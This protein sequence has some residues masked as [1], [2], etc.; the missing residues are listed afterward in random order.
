MVVEQR[1]GRIDRFGQ[2][3]DKVFIHNLVIE[4]TVEETILERLYKRIGIFERSV[5]AIEA[6]LGDTMQKLQR[7]YLNAKMTPDEAAKR[8]EQEA[9]AIAQREQLNEELEQKASQLFG[10]EEYVRSELARVR[11]LG[12]FVGDSA[13]LSILRTFFQVR[14][15]DIKIK[16]EGQDLYAIKMTDQLRMDIHKAAKAAT[17]SWRDRSKNGV[18]RFTTSGEL[19]FEDSG[20]ELI[21]STHP[22]IRAAI[23]DLRKQMEEPKARL[24]AA[25]LEVKAEDAKV[26]PEGNYLVFMAPQIVQGVRN[27][28]LIETI[29]IRS[30]DEQLLSSDDGQRLLYLALETGRPWDAREDN[31]ASAE[32]L[33]KMK[34][35]LTRRTSALR[36]RE[37][38]ENE[39]LYLRRRRAL[40]AEHE[41]DLALK[42]RRLETARSKENT[43]ILPAFEGQ[44]AKAQAEFQQELQNLEGRQHA[45]VSSGE[46][47]SICLVHVSHCIRKGI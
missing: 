16:E 21:G 29:A 11:K 5:G 30:E 9:N 15:L 23:E 39:A 43:K 18:L 35:E 37:Q 6:I 25:W 31:T 20:L 3:S 7:D 10:N 34:S 44:I 46:P 19:A 1:I 33:T 36:N 4:G 12:Q 22:L 28:R 45:S 24:G 38:G 26:F 2:K 8:V 32:T 40:E 13:L 14:H 47:I 27:R 17:V 42:L 41:H